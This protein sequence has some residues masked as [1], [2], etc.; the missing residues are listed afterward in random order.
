MLV[1]FQEGRSTDSL[2]SGFPI[3]R[4]SNT[5]FFKIALVVRQR[6]FKSSFKSEVLT[7]GSC[8]FLA[9]LVVGIG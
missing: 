9:G 5:P 4:I 3:L 2:T 7:V 1:S 6:D 8:L